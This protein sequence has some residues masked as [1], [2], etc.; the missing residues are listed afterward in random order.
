MTRDEQLQF[1]RVCKNQNYDPKIG[2]ICSITDRVADFDVYCANYQE[3]L[4]LK[5]EGEQ[6]KKDLFISIDTANVGQRFFNHLID[7]FFYLLFTFIFTFI[8][9]VILAI[10]APSFIESLDKNSIILNYIL[11]FLSFIVYYTLF[12]FIWGRTP[13]KFI[14]GTIVVDEDGEIPAFGRVLLRTICRFIPFEAFSF[15]GNNAVGWHDRISKTRVI[16]VK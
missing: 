5:V 14:T 8:L 11:A 16:N 2:I 10:V 1:C 13:A 12:E 15:L 6:S 4:G 3:D 9:G 7:S